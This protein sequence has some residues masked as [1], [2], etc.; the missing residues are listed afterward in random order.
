MR[1]YADFLAQKRIEPTNRPIDR[2]RAAPSLF[3]F[4]RDIA[5]WALR[6]AALFA[7]T[8][9]GKSL[10]ELVWA[11]AIHK[12]N[13]PRRAASGAAC[14]VGSTGARGKEIRHRCPAHSIVAGGRAGA[15]T[16][17]TG[18]RA[19]LISIYRVPWRDP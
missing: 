13:R 6:R 19:R 15:S 5:A 8:G 11:D 18:P 9:L 1:E 4:Q 12:E 10:M 17:P 2:S 14:R 16:S 7:G 3:D